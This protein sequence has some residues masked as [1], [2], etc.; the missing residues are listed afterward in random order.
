MLFSWNELS[1]IN[2][3]MHQRIK[4]AKRIWTCQVQRVL[5]FRTATQGLLLIFLPPPCRR[6]TEVRISLPRFS[7]KSLKYKRSGLPTSL[8]LRQERELPMV[9][10]GQDAPCSWNQ[11]THSFCAPTRTSDRTSRYDCNRFRWGNSFL[12]LLCFLYL[13]WFSP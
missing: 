13:P 3:N 7:C 4:A 11:K 10:R 5:E 9:K 1:L 8:F 6:N 12:L 2:K